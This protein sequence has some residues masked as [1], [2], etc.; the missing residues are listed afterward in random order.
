MA[1]VN[2]SRFTVKELVVLIGMFTV[3]F[4]VLLVCIVGIFRPLQPGTSQDVYELLSTIL[5]LVSGLLG[6]AAGGY[7]MGKKESKDGTTTGSTE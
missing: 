6:G 5:G 1:W 2:L 4:V 3:C 7:A